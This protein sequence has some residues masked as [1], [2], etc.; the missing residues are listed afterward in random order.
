MCRRRG[1]GRGGADSGVAA[2]GRREVAENQQADDGDTGKAP[3]DGG[4]EPKT[5]ALTGAAAAAA[6]REVCSRIAGT[7]ELAFIGLMVVAEQRTR[8]CMGTPTGV[9]AHTSLGPGTGETAG[10]TTAF[11]SR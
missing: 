9:G 3:G 7:D 4:S 10:R 8:L 5:M 11:H 6:A 2:A 1:Y